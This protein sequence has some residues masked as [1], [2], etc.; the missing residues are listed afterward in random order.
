MDTK[1]TY[2]L[3]TLQHPAS[4][5]IL[6]EVH[7]THLSYRAVSAM[8]SCGTKTADPDELDDDPN[9]VELVCCSRIQT[10]I[11]DLLSNQKTVPADKSPD[12]DLGASSHDSSLTISPTAPANVM[13]IPASKPMCTAQ[14]K[15][16]SI[17]QGAGKRSRARSSIEPCDPASNSDPDD[18]LPLTTLLGEPAAEPDSH[19]AN[20]EDD[21]ASK[22]MVTFAGKFANGRTPYQQVLWP[23]MTWKQ[24]HS[25]LNRAVRR[26]MTMWCMCIDNVPVDPNARVPLATTPFDSVN[27]SLRSL[28]TP[29]DYEQLRRDG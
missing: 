21:P 15:L 10:I 28:N 27:G 13:T 14:A 3:E 20:D 18:L 8:H 19:T 11:A 6:L 25:E 26:K 29:L 2:P 12:V 1:G 5:W 17:R 9:P 23:E 22:P 7:C 24:A 4:D 16:G